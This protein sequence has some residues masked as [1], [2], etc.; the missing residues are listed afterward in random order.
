MNAL[1]E[2]QKLQIGLANIEGLEYFDEKLKACEASFSQKVDHSDERV[3]EQ[4]MWNKKGVRAN[5]A[6]ILLKIRIVDGRS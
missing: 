2:K 3:S 4:G 6:T 5:F 1:L